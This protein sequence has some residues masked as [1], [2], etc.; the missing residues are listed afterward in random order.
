[1]GEAPVTRGLSSSTSHIAENGFFGPDGQQKQKKV[2]FTYRFMVAVETK[3]LG[4]NRL[5]PRVHA[6]LI[7]CCLN[8]VYT[9]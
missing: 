2:I 9:A 7:F 6:P 1:M 4:Y 5:E 8:A 3:G